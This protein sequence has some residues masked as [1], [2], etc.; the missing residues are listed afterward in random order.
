MDFKNVDINSDV[1]AQLSP[2]CKRKAMKFVVED[3]ALVELQKMT[4]TPEAERTIR[5]GRLSKSL[6]LSAIFNPA[7]NKL[8][9]SSLLG[10]KNFSNLA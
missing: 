7:K 10:Q 9:T 6:V 3:F 1:A 8:Y 2:I 4:K 5:L